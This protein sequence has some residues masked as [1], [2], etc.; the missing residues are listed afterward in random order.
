[1]TGRH[2]CSKLR[3][4]MPPES[5][6]RAQEKARV[7]RE[8]MDQKG[9]NAPAPSLPMPELRGFLRGMD[10]DVERDEDRP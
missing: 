3:A 8:E 7:L 4:A 9:H 6:A 10:T 2:S 1:M 5:Q